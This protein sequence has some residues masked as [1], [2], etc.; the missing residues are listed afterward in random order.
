MLC[1]VSIIKVNKHR[2]LRCNVKNVCFPQGHYETRE[3]FDFLN[4]YKEYVL[5][6]LFNERH[7]YLHSESFCAVQCIQVYIKVSLGGLVPGDTVQTNL[8]WW[9]NLSK[10]WRQLPLE[11]WWQW[12]WR[13]P[14]NEWNCS[15]RNRDFLRAALFSTRASGSGSRGRNVWR[16]FSHVW[17]LQVMSRRIGVSEQS[18]GKVAL[19]CRRADNTQ[20]KRV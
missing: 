1:Q 13:S 18:F 16:H 14:E 4:L 10:A 8:W 20:K 5:S 19:S 7:V 15:P 3:H 6:C 17:S 2:N 9:N 12:W 11:M